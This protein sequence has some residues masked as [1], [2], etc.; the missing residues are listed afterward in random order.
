MNPQ[1]LLDQFKTSGIDAAGKLG[2]N[3]KAIGDSVLVTVDIVERTARDVAAG[4][5]DLKGAEIIAERSFRQ[6]RQSVEAQGNLTAS[7]LLDWLEGLAKFAI[8]LFV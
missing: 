1:D 3:S 7:A 8:K 4:K 6:L 2:K 5:I